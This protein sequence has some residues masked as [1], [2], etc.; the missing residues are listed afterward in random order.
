[1]EILRQLA[2][3][4]P[5]LGCSVRPGQGQFLTLKLQF[6]FVRSNRIEDAQ[7]KI[8]ALVLVAIFTAVQ[9]LFLPFFFL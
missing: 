7:A 1:M 9:F 8:I 6:Y 2:T 3:V 4:H 5:A